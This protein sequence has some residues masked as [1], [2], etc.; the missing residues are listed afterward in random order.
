MTERC[1]LNPC[2][3]D[4]HDCK[5]P[6]QFEP[7]ESYED[8]QQR[9]A[10]P[11]SEPAGGGE[12]TTFGPQFFADVGRD[13]AKWVAALRVRL[14]ADYPSDAVLTDFFAA[15]LSSSAAKPG[16]REVGQVLARLH[17]G[18]FEADHSVTYCPNDRALAAARAVLALF[19]P[20]LA[21]KERQL[22]VVQNAAKTIASAQG[23]ELEHLR[24]NARFDHALRQEVE[25]LRQHNSE[26]TDA[27]LAAEAALAAERERVGQ[28]VRLLDQ[29]MGTPCEQIR[30][31]QDIDNL[32]A[33]TTE[34]IDEIESWGAYASEYFR[35]KH[36]LTGTVA[37]L[38][39]RVAAIRAQAE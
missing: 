36:D 19:A 38:R 21:E 11:A 5:P 10:K 27:L 1:N 17:P 30:Y 8:Y 25:S 18:M 34:A 24:Q 35:D 29:Q 15:A 16:E 20:T 22:R 32:R 7:S 4:H 13:A 26:M 12:K 23:T 39:A 9:I 6:P 31:Q 14:G 28:L 37:D 2:C 33:V 3:G